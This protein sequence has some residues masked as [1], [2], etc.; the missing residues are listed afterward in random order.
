MKIAIKYICFLLLAVSANQFVFAQR[1][2]D[3]SFVITSVKTE[4]PTMIDVLVNSR[5]HLYL[6]FYADNIIRI[7]MD[8][9]GSRPHDPAAMPPAKILV[10]NPR[11]KTAGFQLLDKGT[12]ISITGKSI[13][14]FLE[15]KTGL[16]KIFQKG[17]SQPVLE[18]LMPFVVEANK[19]SLTLKEN[20][21]EYFFGGGVQNGRF[22]HKGKAIAIENQNS[23]TDGGV[24][25]PTPFFWSTNGY[26]MM[27]HTFKP[28][29]YDFGSSE[30]GK[31]KLFHNDSYLD[32]FI[33]IDET[34]AALLGDFYLLTGKPVLLPK[35]GF[36]E[37]HLNAYNRDYWKQDTTGRG[38]L[39]EDGKRYVESQKNNGGTKESLNGEKNNYQFSARGVIDRYK[40]QDMPLGWILP[41]DG[42]GAGYGQTST[43]D[44]NIANL[45]NFGDYARKNGVQIGLW[46]QSDLHPKPGIP[47]LLQRDIE[48]EVGVAG[49]RVLKTDVA[50]VG[51]G[52]SFGLNGVSDAAGIMARHGNNARPFIISL[53]GWA[54]TQ[55]YATVWSGD[56]T[57][58]QWEYIRFHIPTYIGSGLSG[59]PNITSD[60]DGIFGGKNIPV[61]VR[62]FQWKTF[63]PMQLNMDGWGANEKYPH[64]LGEP[65]ASI[66]RMYLKWKSELIPYT[67]SIA[68]QSVDG[69]PYMRAMFLEEKNKFTLGTA[70]QY[71]Y[72]Y[73]P[74]LLVAPIYQNTRADAQGNDVRNNIYLPK[75]KW[76]DYFTGEQFDGGKVINNIAVPI[77]K[78]PVFV[79]AG[80]I[81]PLV[82]P[83][84]NPSEV[85]K[86][87]RIFEFYP[88]GKTSFTLYDDD[89]LTEAYS[90]GQSATTL[91]T[92]QQKANTA[93]IVV[94]PA[95]GSFAGMEKMQATELRIN[96][97]AKPKKLT[98]Y[99]GNAIVNLKPVAT[100]AE[101]NNATNVYWY[102][103]P[104]L[105][106]FATAGSSF[107]NVSIIKNPQ[108]R[109][110][111]AANDITTKQI[112]L[113]IDGFVFAP[114]NNLLKNSGT[115]TAV[116]AAVS[117]NGRKPFSLQP[118]WKR[119]SNADFYEIMF[120]D[121]LH[122]TIND[123]SFVF[124]GLSPETN[125][126]FKIRAVNRSGT[127]GWASLSATTKDNPLKS[128]I[129]GI[130]GRCSMRS[131][132]GEGLANFFDFDESTIWHTHWDSVAVPFTLTID[133]NSMAQVDKLQ[134]LPRSS[135]ANGIWLKG[136]IYYSINKTDWTEA[137]A[138]DWQRNN[139]VK[140]FAFSNQ[141]TIRYIKIVV[142]EAYGKFGSGRELYVFKVPGTDTYMPGDINNDKLIDRNDLTSYLNYTGLRRGDADFEGYI[143]KG[144]LNGNGLIDAYD[145]SAVATKLDGEAWEESNEALSGKIELH[146]GKQAYTTGETVEIT[147][148][149]IGFKVV[150]ALSFALPYNAADFEFIGIE[151]L[152]L[153]QMENFTNDRLHT[154]GQKTLYPTFINI[155]DKETIN[156]TQ[157]LFVIKLR[158]KHNLN[159]ELKAVDGMV[160][161]KRM[162]VVMQ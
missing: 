143:S 135:G 48:K 157:D 61:N 107:E 51:A 126:N 88:S 64:A 32:V 80:T 39:F 136:K 100:E 121:M 4:S 58:G 34:P 131:Q 66:N 7:F 117:E 15:K 111:L 79:K 29:R 72:M 151:P 93:N 63:T 76:T 65:A 145:M 62:D 132:P 69:L 108:V 49:V 3:S 20:A 85:N 57:G 153:K 139:A 71:Q 40:A 11:K 134:Y 128:A 158:A 113:V 77:W 44:S 150:N 24:A 84:N 86:Q 99:I 35:F 159:F 26:A 122:S 148:K 115:L 119:L 19:V 133:L 146:A 112:K 55:R 149:G 162:V 27:W 114:A 31:V 104:N 12:N 45:K 2:N 1:Q 81:I 42:Y 25:S 102:G 21:D 130:S 144:D 82:N 60:M 46:T 78:L 10:D 36:Y 154:N 98:A 96:V 73:G 83:N 155:G 90:H 37:G 8:K 141:P 87:L 97:S 18:S 38:I 52:Y 103:T 110:K 129:K 16:I 56:Q 138:F 161:D 43:L 9:N 54:G 22:S 6:D 120:D 123:T 92:S 109:V 118:A 156:G 137:G 14:I 33:M 140:E 68:R 125:Y 101:L 17:V 74:W 106:R 94:Y 13:I 160:V 75:G 50:W 95:K 124:D 5:Y 59:Q 127:S 47:A 41:N 89:G 91:I 147:V 28:G 67:Y 105:N 70:T 142:S 116:Q 53:D 30:K 152:A 23:W